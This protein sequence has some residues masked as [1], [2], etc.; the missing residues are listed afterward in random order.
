MLVLENV[1]QSRI[2]R[3]R[4]SSHALQVALIWLPAAETYELWGERDD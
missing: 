1:F 4:R 2:D 3:R